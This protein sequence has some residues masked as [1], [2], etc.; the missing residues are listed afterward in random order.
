[1]SMEFSDAEVANVTIN[2]RDDRGRRAS[3]TF[4]DDGVRFHSRRPKQG[5]S[6]FVSYAQLLNLAKEQNS[7]FF[8]RPKRR[9]RPR[10]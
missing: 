4:E 3:L 7:E 1:M 2:V 8:S 10:A 6:S 5:K 9:A